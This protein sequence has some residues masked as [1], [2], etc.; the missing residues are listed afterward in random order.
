MEQNRFKSWAV[1]LALASLI[2]FVAKVYFSYDI[3]Q[4]DALVNSIL[5]AL[6]AF[7]ILN[8]PTDR[9]NF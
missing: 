8:N 5:L 6:T 1:W 3:P 2:S 7:G 4:F 9:Y